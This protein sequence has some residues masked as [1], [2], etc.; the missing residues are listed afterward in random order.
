MSFKPCC[1]IPSKTTYSLYHAHLNN[2]ELASLYKLSIYFPE[3]QSFQ[4]NQGTPFS[5]PIYDDCFIE[6]AKKI[7]H[8]SD[9]DIE[10]NVTSPD[11]TI[12]DS[13]AK[14]YEDDLCLNCSKVNIAIVKGK[15]KIVSLF[16]RI[17]NMISHGYSNIVDDT[18]IGF[19]HPK[20]GAIKYSGVVKV[21]INRLLELLESFNEI[22][23]TSSL[24]RYFLKK[25]DYR[26]YD[27]ISGKTDFLIE[28]EGKKYFLEFKHFGGRYIDVNDLNDYNTR[29]LNFVG[30]PIGPIC[31]P[32][33]A[34]IKAAI[35]PADTDYMYFVV[36]VVQQPVVLVKYYLFSFY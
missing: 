25:L 33:L 21:K 22:T 16:T 32:G 20:F 6:E 15:T 13:I 29:N 1:D 17:R 24:F 14:F 10:I 11:H 35:D 30:L 8:L 19:D 18:F 23:D 28:K 4:S 26:V 2:T 5:N 7:L 9:D 12:P 27:T 31:S 36:L 3:V 34:S